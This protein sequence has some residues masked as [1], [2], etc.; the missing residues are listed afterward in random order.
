MQDE[1]TDLTKTQVVEAL[2]RHWRI[3]TR[4]IEYA[5]FSRDNVGAAVSLT[6]APPLVN[7]NYVEVVGHSD[8]NGRVVVGG[9]AADTGATGDWFVDVPVVGDFDHLIQIVAYDAD[10]NVGTTSFTVRVDTVCAFTV[11][12]PQDGY[13]TSASLVFI[14]GTMEVGAQVNAN[15]LAVATDPAGRYTAQVPLVAG[16]NVVVMTAQ[17]IAGNVAKITR[18]VTFNDPLVPV[19]AALAELAQKA[20][21]LKLLGSYPAASA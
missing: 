9:I 17:D 11:D 15:G 16:L 19:A 18:N 12:S 21:F 14:T 5:V 2:R 3:E 4:D 6:S 8:P 1:P 7:T 13:A 10:G 20:P